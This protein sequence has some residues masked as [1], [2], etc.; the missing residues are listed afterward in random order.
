MDY[1]N[2]YLDYIK[3]NYNNPESKFII[4]LFYFIIVIVFIQILGITINVLV[5]LR[6]LLLKKRQEYT[7]QIDDKNK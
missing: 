2:G 7:V 3:D 1:L 4:Y 6:D 5:V